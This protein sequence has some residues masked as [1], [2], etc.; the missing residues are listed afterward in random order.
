MMTPEQRKEV[1]EVMEVGF[2]IKK[3]YDETM[4]DGKITVG[5]ALNLRYVVEKLPA[6]IKGCDT[7]PDSF[8]QADEEDKKYF[9]T[10]FKDKYDIADDVLEVFVERLFNWVMETLLL[11]KMGVNLAK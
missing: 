11:V 2:G 1:V 10:Y 5:D 4:E 3:A 8:Q 6:A 9:A 7:I